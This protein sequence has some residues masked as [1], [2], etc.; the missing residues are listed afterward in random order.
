VIFNSGNGVARVDDSWFEHAKPGDVLGVPVLLCPVEE[1]I[2]SKGYIMERERFDGADVLHLLLAI[3]PDLDW[4]R[5]L[6]RFE[7]HR[8][9]L[10]TH[11]VLF[12]FVYPGEAWRIPE[13]VWSQLLA[14]LERVRA[15]S[16]QAGRIC[17]GTLI[18]RS[19]YLYDAGE[20]YLD[21]RL[22]PEG[23]MTV[24]DLATWTQAAAGETRSGVP[25]PLVT[26]HA[27]V[28]RDAA[29]PESAGDAVNSDRTRARRVTP[30]RRG[31]PAARKAAPQRRRAR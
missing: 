17:R 22:P 9:V 21:A 2:W 27:K 14:D 3:A 15:M 31:R 29:E 13:P 24:N 16:G 23:E 8:L 1:M 5:L 7:H 19:Q 4:D 6:R 25:K 28:L 11:I 20:G 18:S 26:A 10:L 12:L 30:P